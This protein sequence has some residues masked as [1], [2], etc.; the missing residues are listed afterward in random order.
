MRV[1]D[2]VAFPLPGCLGEDASQLDFPRM[3]REVLDFALSAHRLF[4]YHRDSRPVHLHVENGNR[5]VR[6]G[7]KV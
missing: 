7:R 1:T 4:L 3:R 2:R 5:L 6:Q